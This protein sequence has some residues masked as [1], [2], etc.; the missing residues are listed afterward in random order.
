M[1]VT[2]AFSLIPR[3]KE[4]ALMQACRA[5][6]R[7]GPIADA[8]A[9]MSS[10]VGDGQHT[11]ACLARNAPHGW[12]L[13]ASPL[14]DAQ[15]TSRPSRPPLLTME[16]LGWTSKSLTFDSNST[17]LNPS[18]CQQMCP[19][20]GSLAFEADAPTHTRGSCGAVDRW[21]ESEVMGRF[22]VRV[23]CLKCFLCL[24]TDCPSAL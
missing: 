1:S 13:F 22:V 8:R 6:E 24:P 18:H 9:N 4:W 21:L 14:L 15:S 3:G 12:T 11:T 7:V 5:L 10:S 17:R 20:Q 23:A 2:G 16:Q 19:E